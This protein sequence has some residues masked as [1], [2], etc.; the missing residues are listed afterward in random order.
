MK[1]VAKPRRPARGRVLVA[2]EIFGLT[3]H[4]RSVCDRLAVAGYEALAPDLFAEVLGGRFLPYTT[5]GKAEGLRIKSLIGEEAL[6]GRLEAEA[7]KGE[8]FGVVGFCLGGTLAWLLSERTVVACVVGYYAVGLERHLGV[9][10]S[11]PVLLHFGVHDPATPP[12]TRQAVHES[13]PTVRMHEYDAGHA[14]NRDDDK[15]FHAASAELA[16]KRTLDFYAETFR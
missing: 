4:I 7:G 13:H 8:R 14:F 2:H 9:R 16:W 3:P 1:Y 10:P 5:E 6:A 11:C 15:P 12:A